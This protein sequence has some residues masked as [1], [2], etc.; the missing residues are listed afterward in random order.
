MCSYNRVAGTHACEN[1]ETLGDLKRPD[2]LNFSGWVLSDWGGVHSTIPSA[3]AGLD[4]EM[5]GD[6]Y[7]GAAL[8]AAVAAG[9]VPLSSIDDKV[10]RILTPMFAQGLFDLPQQGHANS[11]VSS[12]RHN[13]LARALGAAGTVL[14]ANAYGLLPFPSTGLTSIAVVGSAAQDEPECCGAG[15][16]GLDPPYLVTPLQGIAARAGPGVNVSYLPSLPTFSNISQW[17]SALRG[18]HYLDFE[19]VECYGLYTLVRSEGLVSTGP[20]DDALQ[21][22]QLDLYYNDV[23]SSNLIL[24]QGMAPPAPGYAYVRPIGWALPLSYTGAVP[25]AVLELWQGRDT[26]TGAREGSHMDFFTLASAASRAEAAAAGYSK[27]ASLGRVALAPPAPPAPLPS[28]AD[29]TVVVVS[30]GSGEGSDRP[31]LSLKDSDTAMLTALLTANPHKVVVVLNGPAAVLMPWAPLAGAIVFQWYPGQEMGSALADVLW[32][33]VN[34]SGRLPVTFPMQEADSPLRS[35]EQY[36]GVD[37]QVNYTERLL[38]G[39]RYWDAMQLEP[40]FPFGVRVCV[41]VCVCVCACGAPSLESSPLSFPP[42]FPLPFF[43]AW[44]LLHHL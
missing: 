8:A 36:P 16:G 21:C 14:L 34:P 28:P 32:G 40:L 10:L 26:P 41:C 22:V 38:I 5:P 24:A 33:D 37:G 6:Q 31:S 30:T 20:C 18:D 23:N 27:V 17:Y 44:P 43:A 19:C 35:P 9:E 1:A 12:A 42:T 7:F 39:Y 3:L 15:S 29:R 13:T 4:V 25:T 2:G 11:N